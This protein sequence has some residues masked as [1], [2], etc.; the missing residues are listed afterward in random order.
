M[1]SPSVSACVVCPPNQTE[2]PE[3][4]AKSRAQE[5]MR[6]KG[7]GHGAT[8]SELKRPENHLVCLLFLIDEETGAQ[9]GEDSAH[10][11]PGSQD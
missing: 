5:Q 7:L 10:S 2:Q 8:V 3:G 11:I 9:R 6:S 4:R 1:I